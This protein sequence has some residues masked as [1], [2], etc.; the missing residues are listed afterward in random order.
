MT[1][2]DTNILVYAHRADSSWHKQADAVVGDLAE[3]KSA[4]AI[5]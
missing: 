5:P 3:A 4:W 1:A 2:V